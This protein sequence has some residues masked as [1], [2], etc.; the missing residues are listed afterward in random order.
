MTAGRYE[1]ASHKGAVGESIERGQLAD[2]VE[3]D[4]GDVVG[5]GGIAG[6]LAGLRLRRPRNRQS[7]PPDELAMR[8]IDEITGVFKTLELDGRKRKQRLRILSFH[9]YNGVV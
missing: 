8:L 2:A 5:N 3:Q 9:G 6:R 1:R 7:R 4:D